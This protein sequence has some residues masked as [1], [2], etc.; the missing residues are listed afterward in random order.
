MRQFSNMIF[1]RLQFETA[2]YFAEWIGE[3]RNVLHASG[4]FGRSPFSYITRE[5]FS[6]QVVHDH[7]M[8]IF[9]AHT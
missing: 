8:P 4:S 9:I 1:S 6:R 7:K 3:K 5:S 2:R